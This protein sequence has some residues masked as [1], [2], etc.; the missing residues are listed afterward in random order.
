MTQESQVLKHLEDFGTID[1]LTALAEYRIMRLAAVVHELRRSGVPIETVMRYNNN[2]KHWAEYRLKSRST[3]GNEERREG[4]D[5][6]RP[7]ENN[8]EI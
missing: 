7:S 5:G 2:G 8:T 4:D 1:P 3:S 6:N